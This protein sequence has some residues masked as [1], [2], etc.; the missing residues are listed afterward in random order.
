MRWTVTGWLI[1]ALLGMAG[2]ANEP[3]P[4]V[5]VC[6]GTECTEQN[7]GAVTYDPA[8]AVPDPD[9]GGRIAALEAKAEADPSAA[10][11][12]G[13]RYY[14]GDG[15]RQD[16]Y[17]SLKWMRSAG[18]RGDRQAQAALGRLYFTGLQEMG[19]DLQEAEFWLTQAADK[20]DRESAA[21][22]AEVRRARA[23]ETAFR[24]ELAQLR[25][26]TVYY[27][28]RGWPY[29][30]SWDAYGR[31]YAYTHPYRYAPYPY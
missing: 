2:C 9:S 29:R 19:Q 27:W 3:K 31:P 17:K 5:T 4:T 21:L 11:D 28:G 10:Y 6:K 30:W 24:R 15:V 1:L 7:R 20:G 23:D 14:R 12:L 13:L 16:G 25:A 26:R 22:L 18:E 8:T